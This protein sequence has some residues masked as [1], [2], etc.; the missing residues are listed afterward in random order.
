[1]SGRFSYTNQQAFT[2]HRQQYHALQPRNNDNA[3]TTPSHAASP[4]IHIHLRPRSRRPLACRLANHPHPPA[5]C[6]DTFY[7]HIRVPEAPEAGDSLHAASPII[8]IHLRSAATLSTST[9]ASPKPPKPATLAPRVD[10]PLFD[11][12]GEERA[13]GIIKAAVAKVDNSGDD[14]G[15]AWR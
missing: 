2:R 4:I 11:I 6:G 12:A 14:D 10:A 8:H 15:A 1:M 9:S 7:I 5:V 13:A 3:I